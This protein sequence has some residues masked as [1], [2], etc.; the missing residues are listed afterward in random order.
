MDRVRFGRALGFGARQAGKAL[1]KAGEAAVASPP[2]VPARNQATQPA[3]Q[4]TIQTGRAAGQKVRAGVGQVRSTSAGVKRGGKRF[5]EAI[6][7]PFVKASSVL[8]LEVTGV[9]FG[10]FALTAAG[11]VWKLRHAYA[12]PGTPR[13]HFWFSIG[14]MLLF[15]W[16]TVSSFLRASRRNRR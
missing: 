3:V 1:W 11:G 6:W 4:K 8:W 14:M 16:F 5:G 9:F 13:E 10:L 7:G 15:G 12:T 2:T